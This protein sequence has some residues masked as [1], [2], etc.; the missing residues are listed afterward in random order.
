MR[1]VLLSNFIDINVPVTTSTLQHPSCND[2][3]VVFPARLVISMTRK[4]NLD[5]SQTCCLFHIGIENN[6]CGSAGR[7]GL[8]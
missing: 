2:I 5:S 8:K 1:D 4:I 6:S 7:V 3:Y